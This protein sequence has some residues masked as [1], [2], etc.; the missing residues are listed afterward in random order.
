M[1][2]VIDPERMP[3]GWAAKSNGHRLVHAFSRGA[4]SRAIR[5]AVVNNMPDPAL[6][7]T[8]LQFLELLDAASGNLPVQVRLYSLPKLPRGERA[9]AHLR[10]CYSEFNDLWD[11]PVDGIIITGTEPRHPTLREEPY[12]DEL[13]QLFDWAEHNS[14]SAVL[15]CLAAHA[16]VLHTEGIERQPLG[17]KQF[18]VFRELKTS[19]HILTRNATSEM[20]F[21]HSRW[22]GLAEEDLTSCGYQVLT[23]S[24][25]AGVNLFVK[26]KN[27][28]LFVHFQGHPEYFTFTLLKEYR[29]D[30][31]RFLRRERETYPLLPV[32]YFAAKTIELLG[33][34]KARALLHPQEEILDAFPERAVEET[35]ENTWRPCALAVYRSWLAYIVSRMSEAP[36]M[37]AVPHAA[38]DGMATE[39]YRGQGIVSD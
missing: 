1:P 28:S 16:G 27:H 23:Q 38:Q 4:S 31:K 39:V 15:S 11:C 2:V 13:T 25:K 12:W 20:H 29:R 30:I 14:S 7:D 10:S 17:E 19:D 26:K 24:A 22:N 3:A 18:G 5:V 8:E 34:F 36:R 9:H 33:D 37:V 6:E 32:G 35:L 21:P